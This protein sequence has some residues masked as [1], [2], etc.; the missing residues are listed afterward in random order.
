MARQSRMTITIERLAEFAVV[1]WGEKW[2]APFAETI[3]KQAGRT[4]A[5]S[6]VHQ[7][8]SGAR[9]VPVW[10]GDA[11]PMLITERISKLRRQVI[12]AHK[13]GREIEEELID[14][15]LPPK[16][17]PAPAPDVDDDGGPAPRI[18]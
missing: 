12:A 13:I 11:M 17:K 16:S 1:A 3:S 8:I 14:Q 4:V 15:I 5:P 9:P 6:Q 10:V 7:W 2:I 18:G